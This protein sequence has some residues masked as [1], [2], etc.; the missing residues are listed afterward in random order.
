MKTTG[1][2]KPHGKEISKTPLIAQRT[3]LAPKVD[4]RKG[5]VVCQT[6]LGLMLSPA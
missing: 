2:P 6:Q 1:K 4:W 5:P 3:R